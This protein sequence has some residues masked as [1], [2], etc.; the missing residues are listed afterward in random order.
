MNETIKPSVALLSNSEY[1][2]MVTDAGAGYST[3]RGLDATRWGEDA[4]RDC[5]GQSRVM[6]VTRP[7]TESGPSVISRYVEWLMSTHLRFTP[8]GPSSCARDGDVETRWAVCVVPDADCEVRAVTLVNHGN[9]L[10]ELELTSFAEVC[11]NHRRADQV[12]PRRSQ[13]RSARR[14]STVKAADFWSAAGHG[15][16][17]RIRSGR[18]DVS[19]LSVPTNGAIEYETDRVSF[20][21]RGRTSAS[22]AA[23]D[24]GGTFVADHRSG[25][26]SR[27]Q[28]ATARASQRKAPVRVA[29]VTGA[30]ETGEAA[31]KIAERFRDPEAIDPA[32]N[33]AKKRCQDELRELSLTVDDVV[34]FNRLAASVVFTNAQLRPRSRRGREPSGT[35]GAVAAWHFR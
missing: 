6:C 24:S 4:T 2:V 32:F 5:R 29:F 9:R 19:A 28:L 33:G 25:V 8:I 21:G 7:L 11:L 1:S 16:R 18:F 13:S 27:F 17:M 30:A 12:S 35:A 23:L 20:L 22:P 15:A 26:G 31:L 10:R 34:L 3:W 14:N